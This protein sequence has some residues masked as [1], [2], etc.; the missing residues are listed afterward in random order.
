MKQYRITVLFS[1]FPVPF[2][3]IQL[4]KPV[5]KELFTS[6]RENCWLAVEYHNRNNEMTS[7]WIAVRDI[8]PQKKKLVCEGMHLSAFSIAELTL[9]LNR[10]KSAKVLRGTYAEVPESLR[11]DIVNNPEKYESIFSQ[12]A[13]LDI[14][15]YLAECFRLDQSPYKTGFVLI[16]RV[17]DE[18]LEE[19]ALPL[20]DAQYAQI[21]KGFL[22]EVNDESMNRLSFKQFGMNLLSAATSRGMYLLAYLPLRLN[23]KRRTLCAVDAPVICTQNTMNG[24]KQSV[25]SF[26]NP[27]DLYL[28]DNFRNNAEAVREAIVRANP[29]I[30]VDDMPYVMEVARDSMLDLYSEYQGIFEMYDE[31]HV[32]APVQAFFGQLTARPKQSKAVPFALTNRQINLDQLLAM[33]HAMRYPLSYIQGPPG[34]GKTMTIVNTVLSAF[35]NHR[36]VL[37]ASFNNHPVD[38]AVSKLRSLR[39]ASGTVPFPVLR[40]GSNEEILKSLKMMRKQIRMMSG[41]KA[42]KQPALKD[43]PQRMENARKLSRF[44]DEYENTLNLIEQRDAMDQLLESSDQMNFSLQ[45]ETQQ[46]PALEKKI[47]QGEKLNIDKALRFV[48]TDFT[49]MKEVLYRMSQKCLM[50]LLDEEYE[51]LRQILEM[52][53]EI[54]MV[55]SFNDWIY[56]DDNLKKLLR[57]YPVVA[58]TC[59][60]SFKIA[61]PKPHFDLVILDEASQC[62][63]AVSLVSI[64]RG[65]SLM[66][67]GD[68]QQ[69]QPVIQLSPIDNEQLKERYGISDEYDYCAS[70]IYKT[71]LA[72]DPVSDEVLLSHHYRCDPKIIGFNNRKYYGGR[73][74][75]DGKSVS[76]NPLVFVDVQ[77][78]ASYT[79]NT[80]PREAQEIIRCIKANPDRNI[81]IITPFVNQKEYITK[82][83]ENAGI[84]NVECGTVHAFQGDEKDVILFSLALSDK[85]GK[86]TYGWLKNNREL[87]NV[88]TS[89][90]RQQL[91]LFASLKDLERLHTPEEADDLY[92]LANYIRTEGTCEITPRPAESRALGIKPYSTA[93]EEA[94]LENLTHALDNAFADGSRYTVHREV[95]VS[96]IF[97]DNPSGM[98]Y[99]YRA[100]FD[101]AVFRKFQKKE[102]PVLAI[103][104]DGMEHLNAETVKERDMKKEAICREHGFELIRVDNTYARR[105]HHIKD[106]LIQYFRS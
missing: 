55:R 60:S 31:N 8:D 26:M 19:G 4:M 50:R 36:T 7:Y 28:L 102:V 93:T 46:K 30:I 104:L 15:T 34:T 22:K 16:E 81:G 69:L 1:F 23:V 52:K 3:T 56:E 29:G 70:S 44:L 76:E 39:G 67:V 49:V 43:S 21:V 101:F 6:I 95:P 85:T 73:L 25:R 58:A 32:T 9:Y 2:A 57:V 78:N 96:Q 53:D 12:A 71:M 97:S 99:F 63:T 103:E 77:D 5:Y 75:M 10:I 47:S 13:N 40:L 27:E 94:F 59:I 62:N 65:K 68:P 100:R 90:A 33:N 84:T 79:R 20:D 86:E 42:K 66:L 98:E 72:C 89:R 35:Y 51:E 17:D 106:I 37:L 83:L 48:N 54:Q 91:Y 45:L 41:T 80:A 14:L 11:D 18:K 61:S 87:I 105:Y 88:S 92:D 64:I 38:E 24:T 82:E 74:K